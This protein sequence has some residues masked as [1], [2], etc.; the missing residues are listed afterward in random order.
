ML[1]MLNEMVKVAEQFD[2]ADSMKARA[3]G[4]TIEIVIDKYNVPPRR[5]I[6]LSRNIGEEGEENVRPD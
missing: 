6:T 4:W 5:M 3:G 1:E 2:C